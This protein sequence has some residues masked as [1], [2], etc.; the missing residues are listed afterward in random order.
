MSTIASPY[1]GTTLPLKLGSDIV[2]T[3]KK[4]VGGFAGLTGLGGP[5]PGWSY[6]L[7]LDQFGLVKQPGEDTLTYINRALASSMFQPGFKD[8][9]PWDL[10]PE[11]STIFNNQTSLTYPGTYYFSASTSQTTACIWGHQ[12]PN[13]NI[14]ILLVPSALSM[15]DTSGL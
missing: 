15:G 1:D 2:D 12:C 14:E 3:I 7:M 11:A 13:L 9:S 4:I 5:A 10:S 8:L 6:D